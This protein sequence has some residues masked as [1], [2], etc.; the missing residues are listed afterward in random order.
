MNIKRYMFA[1]MQFSRKL[2]NQKQKG[3]P[4]MCN[5]DIDLIKDDTKSNTIPKR[6]SVTTRGAESEL[7]LILKIYIK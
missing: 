3:T 1:L 2:L 5:K 7:Y 4:E 6:G